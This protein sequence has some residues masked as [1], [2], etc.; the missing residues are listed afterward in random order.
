[1]RAPQYQPATNGAAPVN[2]RLQA[3]QA[4]TG[5]V[6]E[7]LQNAAEALNQ[8]NAEKEKRDELAARAESGEAALF[9]QDQAGQIMADATSAK[10]LSSQ[11]AH[12]AADEAL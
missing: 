7:A 2:A 8:F 12:K 1:M 9:F 5:I 10:G 4:N 3:P 11:P 6:G